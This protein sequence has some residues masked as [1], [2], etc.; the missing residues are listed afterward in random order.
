LSVVGWVHTQPGYGAFLMARD[1]VYHREN[2]PSEHQVLYVLDPTENMDAFFMYENDKKELRGARGY[3][4]YYDKNE[5]MSEYM[6]AFPLASPK[7][8]RLNIEDETEAAPEEDAARRMRFLLDKRNVMGEKVKKL[9]EKKFAA[10]FVSVSGVLVLAVI[11]MGAGLLRSQERIRGLE[12]NVAEVQTAY[13]GLKDEL[14]TARTAMAWNETS[15]DYADTEVP[16]TEAP[17]PST[18]ITEIHILPAT[19]AVSEASE[20]ISGLSEN[21]PAYYIVKSGDVLRSI[22]KEI[23]GNVSMVEEIV[24]LNG[25]ESPDKIFEGQKLLLP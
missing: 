11:L 4:I 24:A 3:F 14:E 2:F 9:G 25:L 17:M 12:K 16:A 8:N 6:Q 15:A 23:Y 19:E 20:D 7:E 13:S 1:E 22:S 5:Q 21:E 10:Q 18:Q